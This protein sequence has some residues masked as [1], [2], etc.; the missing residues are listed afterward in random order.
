MLQGG[1]FSESQWITTWE[2][3]EGSMAVHAAHWFNHRHETWADVGPKVLYS[4][5]NITSKIS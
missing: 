3:I 5:I 1:R 4:M 2:T